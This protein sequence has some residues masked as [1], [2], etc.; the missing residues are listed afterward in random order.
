MNARFFIYENNSNDS[1][2]EILKELEL[3]YDNIFVKTETKE[4]K[5]RISNIIEARNSLSIFYNGR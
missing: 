3:K 1:T 2:K 5:D 4:S